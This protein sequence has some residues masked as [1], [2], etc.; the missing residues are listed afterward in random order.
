MKTL[1]FTLP[2]PPQGFEYTGE[3]RAPRKG[4]YYQAFNPDGH[5]HQAEYDSSHKAIRFILKPVAPP[6]PDGSLIAH[7]GGIVWIYREGFRCHFSDGT[8]D[9]GLSVNEAKSYHLATN[10]DIIRDIHNYS[11]DKAAVCD[12]IQMDPDVEVC[13]RVRDACLRK[14]GVK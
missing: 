10:D 4:E 9:C 7:V 8:V 12:L 13:Q 5:A 3:Y 14:Y 1:T 6:F 2:D 11:L